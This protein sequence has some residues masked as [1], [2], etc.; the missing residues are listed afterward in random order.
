MC[1]DTKRKDAGPPPGRAR[2]PPAPA[3]GPRGPPG[4][5]SFGVY[6]PRGHADALVERVLG[7]LLNKNKEKL[8]ERIDEFKDNKL[9][10]LLWFEKMY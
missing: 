7:L 5:G 3:P 4:E 2:A 9:G 10:L 1:V 6:E 8:E